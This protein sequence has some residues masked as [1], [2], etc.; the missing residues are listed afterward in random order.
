MHLTAKPEHGYVHPTV[1]AHRE[2]Y[3]STASS[4]SADLSMLRI[5]TMQTMI[6]WLKMRLNKKLMS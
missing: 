2:R 1:V 4:A 5:E 6:S 3:P